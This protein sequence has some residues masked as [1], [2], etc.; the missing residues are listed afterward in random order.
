MFPSC[1]WLCFQEIRTSR[2]VFCRSPHCSTLLQPQ[3]YLPVAPEFLEVVVGADIRREEMHD[4]VAV[5]HHQ[6]ALLCFAVHAAFLLVV[7]FGGFEH[8]FGERVQHAVAG[9][10]ADD[11][12]VGK[13]CYTLDVEKQDILAL[14]VL[15]GFDDLMCKVE[16][17]QVSPHCGYVIA[18]PS[19]EA[20]SS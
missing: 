13:G 15:Q 7:L 18:S 12:I 10:V 11:E 5:V 6:P 2:P 9:A 8:P 4:H 20:I 17:V 16:C 1:A 19:G 3:Q 14:F